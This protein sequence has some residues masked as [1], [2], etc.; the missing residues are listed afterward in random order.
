MSCWLLLWLHQVSA[1][2]AD[3]SERLLSPAHNIIYTNRPLEEATAIFMS[4]DKI[5]NR[6]KEC[7]FSFW[8]QLVTEINHYCQCFCQEGGIAIDYTIISQHRLKQ[9]WSS[10][11]SLNPTLTLLMILLQKNLFAMAFTQTMLYLCLLI[12]LRLF[13]EPARAWARSV[14]LAY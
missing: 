11:I 13:Q 12:F 8:T 14:G 10:C 4:L 3:S 6:Q 2:W 5:C 7:T 9:C 1:R